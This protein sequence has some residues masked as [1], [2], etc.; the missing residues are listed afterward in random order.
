M[1]R[2]GGAVAILSLGP[3]LVDAVAAAEELAAHGLPATVVD[4]R[5]AKPLD[6]A[7]LEQL[8][9]HHEVLVTLEDG[10]SGGFGAAVLHHLAWKG[11]LDG[12]LK[13]RP[14]CFPDRFIDHAAPAKQIE[15]AE[16]SPRHI[17][18][19][20]LSAIGDRTAGTRRA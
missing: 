13:V 9:R 18:R 5:F 1:V 4:A 3:R 6:T 12:G 19:T 20:V 15:M 17:V 11:L 2:E 10:G 8:A 16:L 7:M 14:M